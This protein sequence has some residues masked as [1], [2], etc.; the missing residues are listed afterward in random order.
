MPR[1]GNLVDSIILRSAVL[2]ISVSM[3]V[4]FVFFINSKQPAWAWVTGAVFMLFSAEHIYNFLSRTRI[5]CLNRLS[6]SRTQSVL[7]FLLPLLALC[8]LYYVFGT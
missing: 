8:V 5:L 3:L 6:G 1:S 2:V 7:A 4:G